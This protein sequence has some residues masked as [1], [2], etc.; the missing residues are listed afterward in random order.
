MG[1]SEMIWKVTF[2]GTGERTL[3]EVVYAADDLQDAI[4]LIADG[5]VTIP[6]GSIALRLGLEASAR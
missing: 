2:S 6:E 1:K 3:Q 5:T 4:E